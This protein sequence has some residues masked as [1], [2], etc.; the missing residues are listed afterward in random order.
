MSIPKDRIIDFITQGYLWTTRLRAGSADAMADSRLPLRVLGRSTLLV[1]G[2]QGV[3]LFYDQDRIQ[4]TG[5]MPSVVGGGLFGKGSVH[6][7]DGEQHQVRKALFIRAAMDRPRVDALL[8]DAQQEW[9]RVVELWTAGEELSVYDAAVRVYGRSIIRWAGIDVDEQTRDWIATTQAEIVDGFAVVGPA[10]LKT[11]K[12]RQTMD[13]WFTE[14]VRAVRA[15]EIQIAD[16][17][18]LRMV[19]DHVEADGS[20]L[21]D[22]LA[23]VEVQNLIRP[24]IAVARFAAFL[25]VALAQHPHWRDRVR[26]ETAERSTTIEGP[27]ATAVAEEVRRHFPFVPLLPAVARKDFVFQGE[28]VKQGQRILLDF[29]G[30]NHDENSWQRPHSF[31]PQRFLDDPSHRES[32]HFIPQG[33]GTAQTGH[34]C[35]GEWIAV[36]LLAQTA[37]E[38]S[39]L[40]LELPDDLDWSMTRMPTAPKDGV[41]PRSVGVNSAG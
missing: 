26:A 31:D 14:R 20:A 11:R 15:G 39:E 8:A 27:V 41:L 3:R 21:D 34:R 10:W 25:A 1:N 30:T 38:L 22:H 9:R 13:E 40:V 7:L 28:Q 16:D 32:D 4:R 29:Y 37:S 17:S 35:P 33:G 24:T 23:G 36:G 19:L 18:P 12:D 2:E 6:G 5:A